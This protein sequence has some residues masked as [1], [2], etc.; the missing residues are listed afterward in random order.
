MRPAAKPL[1][2]RAVDR[3]T[4][5]YHAADLEEAVSLMSENPLTCELDEAD[6][7]ANARS[8]MQADRP[9]LLASLDLTGRPDDQA[10]P[11]DSPVEPIVLYGDR[12]QMTSPDAAASFAL[13]IGGRAVPYSGGHVAHLEAP[14]EVAAE[15][16]KLLPTET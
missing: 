7:V 16:E 12:S 3:I 15:I 5:I 13:G 4:A 1:S 14:E 11:V 6:L 9:T 2:E 10:A 8:L